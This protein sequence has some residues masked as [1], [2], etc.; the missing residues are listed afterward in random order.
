MTHS[1][2][3]H[4][5]SRRSDVR[6]DELGAPQLRPSRAQLERLLDGRADR[7]DALVQLTSPAARRRRRSTIKNV[8]AKL[9]AA[10]LLTVGGVAL[11]AT[12]GVAATAASLGQLPNPLPHPN[13]ASKVAAA[14]V[15]R[16][17][18]ASRLSPSAV[19]TGSNPATSPAADLTSGSATGSASATGSGSASF[20]ARSSGTP[21]P[22]LRGLCQSWLSR[23]HQHGQ[24]DTN[25]AFTVLVSTAGG[26][27]AV[28]G[29][30]TTLLSTAA[31]QPTPSASPTGS[32]PTGSGS[33]SHTKGK[34]SPVPTLS[35]PTGKPTAVPSH[36]HPAGH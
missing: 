35:H 18:Q 7:P 32:S 15:G 13:H 1:R 6:P 20:G 19:A 10:K 14:T 33:P 11:A 31:S 34:P 22:S 23:P 30:C 17:K 12:G 4:R 24:A 5:R 9:A 21:S 25:P 26:Q 3:G 29:Y 28:T 2:A 8:G 16:S 27:D 36:S